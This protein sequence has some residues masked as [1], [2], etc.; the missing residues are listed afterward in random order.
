MPFYAQYNLFG[1]NIYMCYD[2]VYLDNC[3]LI[4]VR[5][6]NGRSE[7][8]MEGPTSVGCMCEMVFLGDKTACFDVNAVAL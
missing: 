2:Y 8:E 1:A 6:R 5:E 7:K 4:L 3:E